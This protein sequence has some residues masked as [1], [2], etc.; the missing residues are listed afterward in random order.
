[1]YISAE[2]AEIN[3]FNTKAV[4]KIDWDGTS[5]DN[6]QIYNFDISGLEG[7]TSSTSST[8]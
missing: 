6:A 5:E 4:F 3:S 2:E 1:L 7:A 8:P